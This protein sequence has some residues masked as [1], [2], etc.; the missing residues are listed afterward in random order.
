MVSLVSRAIVN[1]ISSMK[2]SEYVKEQ[3]F[4]NVKSTKNQN[5]KL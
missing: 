5:S 1:F 2:D 4:K 3:F